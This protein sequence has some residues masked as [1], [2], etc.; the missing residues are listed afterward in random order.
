MKISYKRLWILLIEK[1]ITKLQLHKDLNLVT[2]TMR[3]LNK[4]KEAALSLLF[5]IGEHL[6]FDIGDTCE[7]EPLI[8]ST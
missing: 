3:K 6:N 8:K 7:A 4:G 1:D 5:R 2:G